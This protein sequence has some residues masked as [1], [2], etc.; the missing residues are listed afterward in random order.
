MARDVARHNLIVERDL[1]I[2][3]RVALRLQVG[4]EAVRANK[5]AADGRIHRLLVDTGA[6]QV[7]ERLVGALLRLVEANV[8]ERVELRDQA[9]H[10]LLLEL[11]QVL[12]EVRGGK[13]DEDD[14]AILYRYVVAGR[15]S[16]DAVGDVVDA[17]GLRE[18]QPRMVEV[19]RATGA[20]RIGA[21]GDAVGME[22]RRDSEGR[23]ADEFLR[24]GQGADDLGGLGLEVRRVTS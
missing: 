21:E 10:A 17:G 20:R 2:A 4:H 8:A 22:D 9:V 6:G 16:F 23:F 14:V 24:D 13:G 7:R 5:L 18:K 12:V 1:S 3:G 15:T 11:E 19:E